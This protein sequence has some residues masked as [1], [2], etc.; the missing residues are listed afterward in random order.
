MK[1][2]RMALLIVFL[3][4]F[5]MAVVH[6]AIANSPG[7]SFLF[8]HDRTN[9]Y[10][11]WFNTVVASCS[12]T[13]YTENSNIYTPILLAII[14]G[15]HRCDGLGDGAFGLREN[16]DGATFIT[17][18]GILIVSFILCRRIAAE[19]T[20]FK[21]RPIVIGALSMAWP[22]L[23]FAIDRMNTI[24][25]AYVFVLLITFY[26]ARISRNQ[27]DKLI[28]KKNSL[29]IVAWD[30][31]IG[32]VLTSIKPYL[33]IPVLA[34]M[35]VRR[36]LRVKW[37][38][39]EVCLFGA[40][41]YLLNIMPFELGYYAGTIMS[42]LNGF[43]T[44][45]SLSSGDLS[46]IWNMNYYSLSLANQASLLPYPNFNRFLQQDMLPS[47]KVALAVYAGYVIQIVLAI[48]MSYIA[49][50]AV[51]NRRI[52]HNPRPT[53]NLSNTSHNPERAV[54][55]EGYQFARILFLI[56]VFGA[57]S[58]FSPSWG[59][60]VGILWYP[61]I[62]VGLCLASKRIYVLTVSCVIASFVLSALPSLVLNAAL[63]PTSFMYAAM[64]FSSATIASTLSPNAPT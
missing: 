3:T 13:S 56:S 51:L 55:T 25:L 19:I 64:A 11:D 40:G 50:M 47:S 53:N 34:W 2:W 37:R 39:L 48:Y 41:Y 14:R 16:E 52:F 43:K 49:T 1:N 31:S 35:L 58:L 46:N 38:A 57:F 26:A 10:M 61:I 4:L 22:P 28:F 20:I 36:D 5:S 62:L 45:S 63:L 7:G 44:F 9:R 42:W 30:I 23:A 17:G 54:N 18:L 21:N 6:V 12:S 24:L 8:I 60:Y 33:V 15:L 59:L 29:I 27:T 32:I